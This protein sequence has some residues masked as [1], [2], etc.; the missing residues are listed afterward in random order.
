MRI[1][2]DTLTLLGRCAVLCPADA[3]RRHGPGLPIPSQFQPSS[4]SHAQ[5]FLSAALFHLAAGISRPGGSVPFWSHGLLESHGI[6]W[7]FLPHTLQHDSCSP[8]LRECI[9]CRRRTDTIGW[10]SADARNLESFGTHGHACELRRFETSPVGGF[11]G[12]ESHWK[13][14]RAIQ[15]TIRR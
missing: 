9:A 2:D 6:L 3:C 14:C 1:H 11:D 4:L 8:G 12:F 10:S 13:T 15:G 7:R 5:V